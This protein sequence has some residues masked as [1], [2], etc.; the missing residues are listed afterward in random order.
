[1]C[2]KDIKLVC[3][4]VIL[5][6]FELRCFFGLKTTLIFFFIQSKMWET[7]KLLQNTL[8]SSSP[9]LRWFYML[10][11][12]YGVYF[13]FSQLECWFTV[14]EWFGFPSV[15]KR[16]CE[17][18]YLNKKIETKEGVGVSVVCVCVCVA[19]LTCPATPQTWR[20]AKSHQLSVSQSCAWVGGSE[21]HVLLNW[22]SMHRC[23]TNQPPA[24][25]RPELQTSHIHL[26]IGQIKLTRSHG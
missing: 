7:N 22:A 2:H 13:L 21:D 6:P 23:G 18:S 17:N 11:L 8:T 4:V 1:M 24:P 14:L 20:S 15:G 12:N 10:N 3:S 19:G 26:L 16:N 25:L 5:P 9:C